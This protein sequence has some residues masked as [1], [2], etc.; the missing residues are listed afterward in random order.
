MRCRTTQAR[1]EIFCEFGL[2]S[3]F[4]RSRWWDTGQDLEFVC[5]FMYRDEVEVHTQSSW[6][7]RPHHYRIYYVASTTPFSCGT[8][9]AILSEQVGALLTTRHPITAQHLQCSS[10][11][12]LIKRLIWIGSMHTHLYI[13]MVASASQKSSRMSF[14]WCHTVDNQSNNSK[15]SLPSTLTTTN[16][17]STNGSIWMDTIRMDSAKAGQFHCTHSFRIWLQLSLRL[18]NLLNSPLYCLSFTDTRSH[19]KREAKQKWSI[20]VDNEAKPM[21]V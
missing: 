18:R 1:Q 9:R 16:Y 17:V 13:P 19:L 5:V 15:R 2:L 21:S 4:V 6:M 11:C 7:S 3:K 12:K 10:F 20:M 14:R 8:Q